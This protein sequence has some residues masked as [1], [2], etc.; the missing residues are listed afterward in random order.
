MLL[1]LL[2]KQADSLECLVHNSG[3]LS[4]MTDIY[5]LDEIIGYKPN[6]EHLPLLRN[7]TNL[8]YLELSLGNGYIAECF[9]SG[10]F[11]ASLETLR[12]NDSS[13]STVYEY[14]T[15]EPKNYRVLPRLGHKLAVASTAKPLNLE[16]CYVHGYGPGE[17]YGAW[18]NFASDQCREN[19]LKVYEIA[20]VL[21]SRGARMK[22]FIERFE[23]GTSY[24]P[25]YMYGEEEPTERVVYDSMEPFVF[26]GLDYR[27][28]DCE[29]V[30]PEELLAGVDY[31]Q[32]GDTSLEA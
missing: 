1:V 5:T 32:S 20:L 2:Q 25:P 19:R 24:I 22:I 28:Q 17:T 29:N 30:I 31:Y 4:N 7:L 3:K 10:G 15:N 13:Y 26:N 27:K 14:R 18:W 21:K 11:P 16:L 9:K 8:K 23:K 12:L 6:T